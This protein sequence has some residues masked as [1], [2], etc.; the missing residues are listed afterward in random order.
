MMS[1]DQ[2]A[3]PSTRRPAKRAPAVG[4]R[5]RHVTRIAWAFTIPAVAL[6]L[7]LFGGSIIQAL[8]VSLS[9][10]NGIGPIEMEGFENY[11]D[12]LQSAEF[13]RSLGITLGY[14]IASASGIII[15]ATLLAAAISRG[16]KGG[17]FYRVVWFIPGVAPST[18]VAVFWT[19]A[20]QP[21]FG[22]IN[23][24]R[25]V[26]GMSDKTALLSDPKL[27]IYPIILATVWAS[28]GFAFILILGSMEQIP[29][30]V[31]EAAKI[32][33][34]SAIRQFFSLTLP[35]ARPVIGIVG[36]LN[37][38]GCFNNFA[39]IW[40]MTQGGPGAAT[41]T[42]PVLVYKVAFQRAHY[43]QGTAIAVIAGTI[44]IILGLITQRLSRS[45]GDGHF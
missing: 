28:A 16:V 18:A 10:W 44:L 32:D 6:V 36:T 37:L 5:R 23:A 8:Q 42:L 2:S 11:S 35:L 19:T 29:V 17:W 3:P 33:G 7:L 14:S 4:A 39:L 38:I 21:E 13:Y 15:V 1:L 40:G 30:S 45:R 26:F 25:A 31:Y 22:T 41:T 20:W 9:D 12:Q 24:L 27:A 43:G 34:A